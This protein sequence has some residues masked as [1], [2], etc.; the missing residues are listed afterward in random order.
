M[1]E[2]DILKISERLC[3]RGFLR[4]TGIDEGT[5]RYELTLAG[6]IALLH[7]AKAAN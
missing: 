1:T 3:E 2:A 5:P 4:C 7:S 6:R